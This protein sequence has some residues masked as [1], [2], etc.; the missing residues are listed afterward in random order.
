MHINGKANAYKSQ[1]RLYASRNKKLSIFK[2]VS[3]NYCIYFGGYKMSQAGDIILND[4]QVTLFVDS[5]F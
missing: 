2:T 1:Q 4:G 5:K 3:H